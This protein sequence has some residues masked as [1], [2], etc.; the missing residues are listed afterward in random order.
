VNIDVPSCDFD[1]TNRYNFMF[2]SKSAS[3]SLQGT[4]SSV[5]W[6][7]K[8]WLNKDDT[9]TVVTTPLNTIRYVVTANNGTCAPAYDTILVTVVQP[10]PIELSATPNQIFIGLNSDLL[11]KYAGITDSIVWSPDSTLSCRTCKTPVASPSVTTTYRATIYYSK[12]GITCSNESEIT[13]T[14]IQT[15]GDEIVYIPNT[16]TP[17]GDGFNDVFRIRGNGISQINHFRSL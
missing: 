4:F 17:N 16:F 11:A 1:I 9:A 15:C 12:N 2:G 6:S 14:V 3:L 5:S 7:P 13:I 8:N 10:I